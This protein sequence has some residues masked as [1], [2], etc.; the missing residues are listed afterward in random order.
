MFIISE[1]FES[2]YYFTKLSCEMSGLWPYQ[3]NKSAAKILIIWFFINHLVLTPMVGIFFNYLINFKSF[4]IQFQIFKRHEI[5][6]RIIIF[7]KLTIC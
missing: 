7:F 5:S 1:P 2:Y 3:S 4:F 6:K